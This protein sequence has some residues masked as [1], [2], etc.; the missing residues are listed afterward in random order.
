MY[1]GKIIENDTVNCIDGITVSLFMSGCPH[2]CKGCF[3]EETW[4]PTFGTEIKVD[5]L[6]SLLK[7]KI[8]AY[9]IKRHFSVLGGEP[10]APY[11]IEN[12]LTIVSTI[13]KEFNDIEIYLWSGYTIEEINKMNNSKEILNNINYLIEGRFVESKKDLKLKLRGSSNQRIFKNVNNHMI[14]VNM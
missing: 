14:E 9:D 5:D 8:N 7:D 2:H 6:I 12:T 4:N 13:R 1:Y 11:N 10:L 3:N